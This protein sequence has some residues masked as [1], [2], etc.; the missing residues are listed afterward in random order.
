M[1]LRLTLIAVFLTAFLIRGFSWFCY[2]Y[3]TGTDYGHHTIYADL[4]T[5]TG[6]LPDTFPF[7]Q[8]GSSR[9]SNLP[10]AAFTYAL[11]SALSGRSA[12]EL[13]AITAVFSIIEVAG[14]YL[15]AFRLFQRFDIACSAALV[16][17][18]LP[19]GA[20]MIAWSAFAN[21]VALALLPYGL[22]AWLNYWDRPSV[23]SGILAVVSICAIASIHHL[24]LAWLSLTL[25][26]FSV[27]LL[28]YRPLESMRKLLP[29]VVTGCLVGLP[30]IY[31]VLELS[32]LFATGGLWAGSGRFDATRLTWSNWSQTGSAFAVVFLSGGLG[33]F[34]KG[35]S[36]SAFVLIGSYTVVSF[37]FAFGWLFGVDF[38]YVRALYF[39]TIPSAIGASA[40][41]CMSARPLVRLVAGAAVVTTLGVGTLVESK[42]SAEWYEALSPK[43]ME[44]TEW[45]REFSEPEDVVVV[46]TTLG[47]HMPRLLARP[48]MVALTPDLMG[49]PDD[50]A[51]A[52]DAM[53]ILKGL[54]AM[55]EALER[56]RVKYI[57]VRAAQRD[58]P[59]A[60]RSRAV[61]A[62]HP[63][64]VL[65]FQNAEV[66]IYGVESP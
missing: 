31:R 45:L 48:I 64:L 55:D 41:L 46:G 8:L 27:V 14:V 28:V 49:N 12:F 43:V 57:V 36:L 47:Y 52:E 61:L 37:F 15:L 40:L 29:I 26:A 58:M 3:P 34:F 62:A 10:G 1:R 56:R 18:L 32:Q 35:A 60:Y 51:V 54:D 25:I 17:A 16:V 44:A 59:D 30:I 7:Y 39:L 42:L 23:R 22:L 6:R 65:L 19:S 9:W 2:A 63:R 5:E 50:I 53:R 20:M 11:L 24:T 21:I 66:M 33:F 38:Y 4:Y 13:A